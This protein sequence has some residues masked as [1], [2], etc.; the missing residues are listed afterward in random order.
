MIAALTALSM[1]LGGTPAEEVP[2]GWAADEAGVYRVSFDPGRQLGFG[3]G[4]RVDGHGQARGA[5]WM[6]LRLRRAGPP[7]GT[8]PERT[9]WKRDTR[10]LSVLVEPSRPERLE[11]T[12]YEGHYT[13]WSADPYVVLPTSPPKRL[14]F[15]FH[16]GFSARLLDL[17]LQSPPPGHE[18]ELG[19][20]AA[21]VHLDLWPGSSPG[22]WLRV[23]AGLRF[24]LLVEAPDPA[25]SGAPDPASE[26][27]SLSDRTR[28][29]LAPFTATT[30]ALHHESGDGLWRLDA[31]AELVPR[32]SPE[33]EWTWTLDA[34]GRVERILMAID[35]R[36]IAATMEVAWAREAGVSVV[37]GLTAGLPLD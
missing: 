15:P 20:A 24:D 25:T 14:W 10:L 16:A 30:L 22:T 21:G 4:A 23:G 26:E 28:W 35:D 33:S 34:R 3:G 31:S 5:L 27:A 37:A 2:K 6:E 17:D 9:R 29:A 36:P 18:A 1:A 12:A 11:L 13:A 8:T 7:D 19:V 32:W